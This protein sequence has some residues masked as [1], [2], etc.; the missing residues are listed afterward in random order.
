VQLTS[1]ILIFVELYLSI[2]SAVHSQIASVFSIFVAIQA[3]FALYS[4]FGL[5][6]HRFVLISQSYFATL[7]VAA[8]A[9]GYLFECVRNGVFNEIS[10][11]LMT[12]V[13]TF[14]AFLGFAL[15]V[16]RDDYKT[17]ERCLKTMENVNKAFSSD[18]WKTHQFKG[19]NVSEKVSAFVVLS[20]EVIFALAALFTF[21]GLQ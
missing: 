14:D 19:K 21:S 10:F 4:F 11:F 3:V 16:S 15:L 7:K 17:E 9:L 12:V 6:N 1:G 13:L 8:V 18:N 5:P 2:M 20:F